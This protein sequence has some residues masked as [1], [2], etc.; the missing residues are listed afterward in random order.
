[1]IE[2]GR[3]QYSKIPADVRFCPVCATSEMKMKNIS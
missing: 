3:Y 1:M 2:T